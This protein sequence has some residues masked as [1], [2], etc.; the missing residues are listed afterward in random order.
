MSWL[1]QILL[2]V[3]AWLC[4]YAAAE[5]AA[6]GNWLGGGINLLPGLVAHAALTTQIGVVAGLAVFGGLAFDVLAANRLGVSVGPLFIVG[7]LIH[8]RRRLI[9]KDQSAAQLWV[10][11]GA[12]LFTPAASLAL[13]SLGQR[14]AIAGWGAAAPLI[15]SGLANAAAGPGWRALFDWIEE[16]F[17]EP[18]AD[19]TSFRADREIKRGRT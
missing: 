1:P 9:L 8:Q 13:L 14:H 17:G 2:F 4:A 11:L 16:T 12:G 15:A 18:R 19:S 7:W 3:A 10:G 6:A 5:F